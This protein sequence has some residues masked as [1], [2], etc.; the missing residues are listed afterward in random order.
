[1]LKKIATLILIL[2]IG[3][4]LGS[5]FGIAHDQI[6]Y[7]ISEEYYTKF[8]FF[9]FGLMNWGWG[10]NVGSGKAPEI[11]LEN[12]RSGVMVVGILATWWVG[13]IISILLGVIGLIHKTA[14]DMF[15]VTLKAMIWNIVFA[16]LTGLFGLVYGKFFLSYTPSLWFLP[17]NIKDRTAFEM[18]GSMHTFSYL[19]G[20]L[21]L[22][23]GI[24]YSLRERWKAN[25]IETQK[26]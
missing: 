26:V 8:K 5:V 11:I 17:D 18:V 21:G 22:L 20:F 24:G 9:Q 23:F 3:P 12:P 2:L 13:F 7:T 25:N 4:V 6:T 1:M 19:G 14:K 10:V 15:R 16:L